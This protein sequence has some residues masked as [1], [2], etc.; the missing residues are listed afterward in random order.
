MKTYTHRI[1]A[2]NYWV[3][4]T[5]FDEVKEAVG[6]FMEKNDYGVVYENISGKDVLA[7][8]FDSYYGLVKV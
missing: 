6:K 1:K 2:S 8:R 3:Y 5:G 7:W 4:V